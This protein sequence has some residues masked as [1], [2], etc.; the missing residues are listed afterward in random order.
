M[1]IARCLWLGNLYHD[2]PELPLLFYAQ[3]YRF[4]MLSAWLGTIIA[5]ESMTSRQSV[6]VAV[7]MSEAHASTRHL[8]HN[9]FLWFH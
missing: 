1:S 2:L 9:M 6:C 3:R 8:K 7:I 4:A 5:V